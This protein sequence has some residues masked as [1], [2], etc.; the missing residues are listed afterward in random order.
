MCPKYSENDS[1][2][3]R[4]RERATVAHTHEI[5]VEKKQSIQTTNTIELKTIQATNKWPPHAIKL[6]YK[7]LYLNGCAAERRKKNSATTQSMGNTWNVIPF[8]R[9][10]FSNVV[11]RLIESNFSIAN[12]RVVCRPL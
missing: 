2:A 3:N 10:M 9:L 6:S 11:F 5:E 12:V 8:D 7:L 4:D 1:L